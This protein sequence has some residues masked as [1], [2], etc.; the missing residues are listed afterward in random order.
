M[1]IAFFS[2]ADFEGKIKRDYE[3]MRV[4]YA[5]YIGLD[6]THHYLGNLYH[7]RFLW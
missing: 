4:E 5:W 2:E 3:N 6:A 1:K 7:S